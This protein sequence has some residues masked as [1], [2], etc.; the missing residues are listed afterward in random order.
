MKTS[1]RTIVGKAI[2]GIVIKTVKSR[3][4]Y[5][6]MALFLGFTDGTYFELYTTADGALRPTSGVRSGGLKE[7]L[8]YGADGMFAVQVDWQD[9]ASGVR[10]E[11][12]AIPDPRWSPGSPGWE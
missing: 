1:A 4:G 3:S 10:T 11:R 2:T 8:D 6:R 7:I 5:I 9:P 12:Y